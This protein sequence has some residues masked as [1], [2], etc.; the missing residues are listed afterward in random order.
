MIKLWRKFDWVLFVTALALVIIGIMMIYSSYE[1][2][3]SGGGDR[4][5]IENTV[6][7]Q[8][9]FAVIGFVAYF[10][11]AA[12]DYY[13]LV[14]LSRWIY[15]FGILFL[16]ITLLVGQ[17]QF[18]ARSWLNLVNTFGGQPAELVKVLMIIVLARYLGHGQGDMETIR[19]LLIS[20][21]ILIP[22]AAL[23]Y[24][25]PDFGTALILM[26]T[27]AGMIF[28]AGVRWRFLV[29]LGSIAATLAPVVWFRMEDYMRQRIVTFLYPEH[30]PSGASYNIMQAL[31]S[32]GSGGLWGKGL[33][34]GTQSQ[35]HFLRVR[36]TDF[37]FSVIAEEF[38]FIGSVL[39]LG[40]FIVLLLRLVRIGLEARDTYGR[41][42]AGGVA[43]MIFV[44]AFINLAMNANLIPVTGLPLPLVSYGGSSLINTLL[45][46]GLAQSVAM[47]HKRADNP[48]I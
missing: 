47:R 7:R 6:F 31:I 35:L 23:I 30:D 44:Q 45:A 33:L 1:A 43:T 39:L 26:A 20:I 17:T 12:I 27:W 48:L 24:V 25:Q 37:I 14:A 34:Q 36:H 18:G 8:G 42:I 29:L 46:L 22:P 13:E 19:P 16:A 9:L 41:L 40:L 2:S 32:I 11:L 5:L 28:L 4:P 3:L 21:L 38:G 10:V 15:L